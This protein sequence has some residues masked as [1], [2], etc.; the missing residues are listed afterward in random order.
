MSQVFAGNLG[1]LFR[2]G[3]D[4][5]ALQHG[6]NEIADTLGAPARARRVALLGRFDIACQRFDVRRH[7]GIAGGAHGRMRGVGFLHQRSEQAGELRHVAG[8]NRDTEVHITEHSVARIWR[9]VIGRA[10]KSSARPL[11]PIRDRA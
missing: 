10:G 6:L 2:L 3:E 11:V 7:A 8:K 9:G 5:R 1:T 4:E